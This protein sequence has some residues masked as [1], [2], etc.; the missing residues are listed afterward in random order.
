MPAATEREAQIQLEKKCHLQKHQYEQDIGRTPF[1]KDKLASLNGNEKHQKAN[2]HVTSD[3]RETAA[4]IQ[5]DK[6]I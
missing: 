6:V 3:A 5:G 4:F 1:Q 2:C